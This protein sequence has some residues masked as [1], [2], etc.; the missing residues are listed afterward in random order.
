M[1]IKSL[2]LFAET[3]HYAYFFKL[4]KINVIFKMT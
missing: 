3:T 2:Q 4:Y 1:R